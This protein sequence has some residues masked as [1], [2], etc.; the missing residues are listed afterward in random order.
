MDNVSGSD[1]FKRFGAGCMLYALFYTLCLYHNASGITYPFFAGGTLWFFGHYTKE[2]Q[3]RSADGKKAF[4]NYFLMV[5]VLAAGTL[6]CFTDSGVLIFFNKVL[7]YT[8]FF[9][10][11]LQMSHDISGWSIGESVK[12]IL[13]II[14][15]SVGRCTCLISDMWAAKML[16]PVQKDKKEDISGRRHKVI[17]IV[18]GLV[19]SIP[20][21][22]FILLLLGNADALFFELIDNMVS[23]MMHIDIS[24]DI[25]DILIKPAVRVVIVFCISYGIF[26]YCTDKKRVSEI[27]DI[28]SKQPARF[29]VYIAITVNAIVAVIYLIF[30]FIQIFGLFLGKMQL[31][32]GFTY[33]EYA[34]KGFF[35]LLFVCVFNVVLVLCTLR[36]FN[37]SKVLKYI[38]TLISGCTY[39]MIASSAFRMVMYIKEYNLTFLRVFVLWALLIIA[40]IM[41]GVIFSIHDSGFKLFKY[42]VITFTVGWLCFSALHPDYWIARYDM[43]READMYYLT[44][45]LS[46]DAV[47]A[48]IGADEFVKE[49]HIN[50]VN[51]RIK[52]K[53]NGLRSFNV[54]RAFAKF[55]I[56]YRLF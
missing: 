27:D 45:S 47:P 13:R 8:L 32:D 4:N 17:S 33:A 20:V 21:V 38:L 34:R 9:I 39:I 30:S 24:D 14:S 23:S 26:S 3:S 56:T 42:I 35:D 16:A 29:D 53:E 52:E 1:R 2:L 37:A 46:L 7:M 31:P 19:I 51:K 15:G 18:I 25:V 44:H 41:A 12:A 50:Q 11:L 49:G 54:S 6:N 22:F 36:Y 40:V 5:S 43:S 10:W 48:Y 28:A 55:L